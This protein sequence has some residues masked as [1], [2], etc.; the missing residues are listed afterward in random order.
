[1]PHRRTSGAGRFRRHSSPFRFMR[2]S[3]KSRY[4][5]PR[6]PVMTPTG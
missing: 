3:R 5:A 6:M 2:T 1:L 4:G